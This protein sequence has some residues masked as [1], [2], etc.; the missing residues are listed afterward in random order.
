M[1]KES[2][3]MIRKAKINGINIFLIPFALLL[4]LNSKPKM[5]N[6]FYKT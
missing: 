2:D 1:E 4:I 5:L 6:I 3:A